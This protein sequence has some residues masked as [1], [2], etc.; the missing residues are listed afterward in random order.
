MDILAKIELKIWCDLHFV[1]LSLKN[2]KGNMT[3]KD[4]LLG[5]VA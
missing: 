1:T 4:G 5:S 2:V 3:S